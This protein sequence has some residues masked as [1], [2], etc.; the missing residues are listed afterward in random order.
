MATQVE[1]PTL[2]TIQELKAEYKKPKEEKILEVL[3]TI[4]DYRPIGAEKEI[5]QNSVARLVDEWFRLKM[6][7]NYD[8]LCED[9]FELKRSVTIDTGK[10]KAG[11]GY[12][13]DDLSVNVQ[14]PLFCSVNLGQPEWAHKVSGE[15][16]G[17]DYNKKYYSIELS[18]KSP[19]IP[20]EAIR[21]ATE[22][23]RYCYEIYMTAMKTKPL[24]QILTLASGIF[25]EP[26]Q[27]ELKLLWYARPADLKVKVTEINKDPAIVLVWRRPYLV[28]QWNENTLPLEDLMLDALKP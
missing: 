8:A 5:R 1:I 23:K 2:K 28:Y 16:S 10:H 21:A 7:G 14:I 15:T 17:Y 24:D 13:H 12:R 11:E 25:P 26:A 22:A 3:K 6:A 18:S 4:Y 19:F 20:A 9:I 27:T